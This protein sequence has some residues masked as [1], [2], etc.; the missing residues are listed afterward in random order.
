MPTEFF[1][2]LFMAVRRPMKIGRSRAISEHLIRKAGLTRAS[3][4]TGA[5]TLIQ[6]FGS[7][8]NADK[9]T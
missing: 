8:L 7:A 1:D 9:H 6:R 5:V 3:A 4:V 2:R